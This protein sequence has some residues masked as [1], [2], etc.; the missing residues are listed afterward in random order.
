MLFAISRGSDGSGAERYVVYV[1][2]TLAPGVSLQALDRPAVLPGPGY[3]LTLERLQYLHAIMLGTFGSP[4]EA[5]S[6][7]NK[8]RASL[9]W[10]SLKF[11]CGV[12][13]PKVL[14]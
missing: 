3:Q 5:R 8:A 4:E 11:N 13:Y 12:S 14:S 9:L 1:P 7:V 6:Y 2:F 10:L